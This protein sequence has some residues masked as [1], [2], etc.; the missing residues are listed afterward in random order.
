MYR[1]IVRERRY[2]R[3]VIR[4]KIFVQ[5]LIAGKPRPEHVRAAAEAEL[6]R[7]VVP[8]PPA[9]RHRQHLLWP[10]SDHGEDH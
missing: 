8:A 2:R 4:A 10:S 1:A 7:M 9:P 3:P 5:D 6:A